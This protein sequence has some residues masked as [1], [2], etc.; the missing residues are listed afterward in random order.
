MLL[1]LRSRLESVKIL[2]SYTNI[3]LQFLIDTLEGL[4]RIIREIV[5]N[6]EISNLVGEL[7]QIFAVF[8]EIRFILGQ[9]KKSGREIKEM[10]RVFLNSLKCKDSL[11][12]IYEIVKKRFKMYD[13]ELY[14]SCDNKFVPRTN[15]EPEDF[16]KII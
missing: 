3:D 5:D 6:F 9:V 11:V 14:I 15:N 4:D 16:N 7:E 1:T 8:Q 2:A 13:N 12:E 10:V